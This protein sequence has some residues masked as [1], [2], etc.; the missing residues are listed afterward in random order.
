MLIVGG[1][2]NNKGAIL[3]AFVVWALWTV[4]EFGLLAALP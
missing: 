1:S 4:T 2:G 3:G